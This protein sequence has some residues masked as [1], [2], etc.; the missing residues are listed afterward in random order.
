MRLRRWVPVATIAGVATLAAG[1]GSGPDSTVAQRVARSFYAEV[2]SGDFA[3]ACAL[4]SPEARDA[5]QYSEMRPCAAVLGEQQLTGGAVRDV[6]VFGRAAIVRLDADTAFLG[7][8][9]GG[10]QIT[11]AGCVEGEHEKYKCVLGAG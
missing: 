2:S 10:W 3:A 4:L 6:E 5:L 9:P 8:F 11:A 1:C 7:E